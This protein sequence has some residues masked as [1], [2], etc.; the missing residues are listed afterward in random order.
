MTLPLAHQRPTAR[1]TIRQAASK[2][3]PCKAAVHQRMLE[4]P[5]EDGPS[6]IAT[7][8]RAARGETASDKRSLLNGQMQGGGHQAEGDAE[9]PHDIVGLQR[10][11]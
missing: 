9:T 11:V 8:G 3:T 5:S 6:D 1:A 4:R 10:V 7:S 2:P